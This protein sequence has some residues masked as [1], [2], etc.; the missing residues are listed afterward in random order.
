MY[1]QCNMAHLGTYL[2]AT[3]IQGVDPYGPPVLVG[4]WVRLSSQASGGAKPVWSVIGTFPWA[5]DGEG[6]PSAEYVR[7]AAYVSLICGAKGLLYFSYHFDQHKLNESPL[8]EP[9][10]ELNREVADLAPWL[11]ACEPTPVEVSGDLVEAALF[12]DGDTTVLLAANTS[13][14][15]AAEV[16]VAVP[17]HVGEAR[18]LFSREVHACDGGLSLALPPYGTAAF[19]LPD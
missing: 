2:A 10:G 9:L 4:D 17:G 15:V 11:L 12:T 18:G 8:W 16:E 6:L 19:R 1:V 3:D 13:E 7:C 14:D 5:G